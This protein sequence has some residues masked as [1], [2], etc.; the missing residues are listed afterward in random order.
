MFSQKNVA[1]AIEQGFEPVWQSLRP[2]PI[3]RIDF[4][5]GN[6]LTRTLH[7]N[8]ATYLCTA[9]GQVLDILP[10]IYEPA[11]YIRR[12]D[13]ARMLARYV[14]EV[15]PS[16]RDARLTNYHQQQ[17]ERLEIGMDAWTLTAS[18]TVPAWSKASIEDPVEHVVFGQDEPELILPSSRKTLL[19]RDTRFNETARR[20][21][22]ERKLAACGRCLPLDLTRWLYREVLKADLDDPYLGLGKKLFPTYP[23]QD[24]Q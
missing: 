5:K 22:I 9:E 10:G 16:Y 11:T 3:V 12:L 21:P 8:V 2:V 24:G 18:R 1:R 17:A 6:V 4:G 19:A 15:E 23:F 7:G 20:L 13:Q 14:N